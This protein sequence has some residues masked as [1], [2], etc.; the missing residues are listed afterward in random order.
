MYITE[1]THPPF[2]KIIVFVILSELVAINRWYVPGWHSI[3]SAPLMTHALI[4]I[5]VVNWFWAAPF[6]RL[7][8]TLL[9]H[10]HPHPENQFGGLQWNT[11]PIDILIKWTDWL[12]DE[13]SGI[14]THMLPT[15]YHNVANC[16]KSWIPI[17]IAEYLLA[18]A[19]SLWS[20]LGQYKL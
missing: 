11:A 9:S 15:N 18:K 12:T 16:W 20:S 13:C 10:P 5:G 19:I 8:P 7:F 17:T 3:L 1:S 6:L 2:T 4:F 14:F